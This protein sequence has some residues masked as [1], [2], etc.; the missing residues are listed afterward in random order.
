MS[1]FFLPFAGDDVTR[2]VAALLAPDVIVESTE[3]SATRC[4]KI[5]ER[6]TSSS[7]ESET[8]RLMPTQGLLTGKIG[9]ASCRERV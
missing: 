2:F 8:P 7:S 9:R 3:V 5:L 6:G 1:A 4:E